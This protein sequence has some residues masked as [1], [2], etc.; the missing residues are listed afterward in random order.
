MKELS[1]E[2]MRQVQLTAYVLINNIR[3]KD[4]TKMACEVVK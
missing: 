1:K 2:A 4:M 3:Q